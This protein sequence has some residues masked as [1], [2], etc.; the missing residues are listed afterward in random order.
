MS[1]TINTPVNFPTIGSYQE[2]VRQ[3]WLHPHASDSAQLHTRAKFEEEIDEL[4][5]AIKSNN[6]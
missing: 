4:R 3:D 6:A 2:W 1:E 5:S